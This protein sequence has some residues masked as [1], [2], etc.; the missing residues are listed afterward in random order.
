MDLVFNQ[1]FG[2]YFGA[3]LG[4][5]SSSKS[6]P[7]LNHFWNCFLCLSGVDKGSEQFD[8]EAVGKVRGCFKYTHKKKGRGWSTVIICLLRAPGPPGLHCCSPLGLLS[9]CLPR[10]VPLVLQT[11][12][13]SKVL[14]RLGKGPC[15]FWYRS[16]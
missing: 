3:S 1:L 12:A 16:P 11:L 7:K 5:I 2:I 4:F 13:T 14:K 8:C 15:A 10:A 9:F 6:K